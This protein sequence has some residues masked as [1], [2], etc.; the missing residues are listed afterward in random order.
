MGMGQPFEHDCA[1]LRAM[2]AG[3]SLSS[4]DQTTIMYVTRLRFLGRACWRISMG[5]RFACTERRSRRPRYSSAPS[6]D[7]AMNEAVV[8]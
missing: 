6:A 1:C 4:A 3:L 8:V 5:L 2:L 7:R